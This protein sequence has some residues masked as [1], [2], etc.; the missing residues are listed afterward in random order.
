MPD[1]MMH[2]FRWLTT[3]CRRPRAL[4]G[5]G[6]SAPACSGRRLGPWAGPNGMYS[7]L[8]RYLLSRRTCSI[9]FWSF[10]ASEWC[11]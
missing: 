8:P 10:D 2:S 7:Y 5:P 11:M 1:L 6:L 4:A 3:T 9:A